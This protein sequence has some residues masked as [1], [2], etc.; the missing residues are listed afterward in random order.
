MGV[1]LIVPPEIEPEIEPVSVFPA[2]TVTPARV[3][4]K[5]SCVPMETRMSLS[6]A[7]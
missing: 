1:P 6:P 3:N 4:L 7:R 2:G 5:T